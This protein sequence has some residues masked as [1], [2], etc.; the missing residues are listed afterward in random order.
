MNE[1]F[2]KYKFIEILS[3]SNAYITYTY[4]NL[5]EK[6]VLIKYLKCIKSAGINNINNN[7]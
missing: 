4:E 2:K 5:L 7:N 3:V 1:Y 6:N